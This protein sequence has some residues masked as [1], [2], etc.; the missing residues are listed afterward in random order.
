M[1]LW[2]VLGPPPFAKANQLRSD[3]DQ[4]NPKTEKVY[5]GASL[6][7]STIRHEKLSIAYHN[8]QPYADS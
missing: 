4:Y 3:P 2:E 1:A 8:R 7:K 6:I 5:V